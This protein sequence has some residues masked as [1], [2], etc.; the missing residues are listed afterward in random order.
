[1]RPR[2]QSFDILQIVGNIRI[3][4]DVFRRNEQWLFHDGQMMPIQRS[5]SK[6]VNGYVQ[7]TLLG[8]SFGTDTTEAGEVPG[9][10]FRNNILMLGPEKK[11]NG[12][13]GKLLGTKTFT[14][15]DSGVSQPGVSIN[16]TVTEIPCSQF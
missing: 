5:G 14:L 12:L 2:K 13:E 3:G 8:T 6:G 7:I 1:M 11:G 4:V 10:W 15:L 16:K 9:T